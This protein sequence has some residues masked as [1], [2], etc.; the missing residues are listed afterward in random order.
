MSGRFKV[1]GIAQSI[2]PLDLEPVPGIPQC[3]QKPIVLNWNPGARYSIRGDD[4]TG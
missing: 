1:T 4:E 3:A 2:L